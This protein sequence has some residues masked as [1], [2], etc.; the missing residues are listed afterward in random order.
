MELNGVAS[1]EITPPLTLDMSSGDGGSAGCPRR[2]NSLVIFTNAAS[3]RERRSS[4]VKFLKFADESSC[5]TFIAVFN[6]NILSLK[7]G[8]QQMVSGTSSSAGSKSAEPL[9][10]AH[11]FTSLY[12]SAM[13][14]RCVAI[15]VGASDATMNKKSPSDS[16]GDFQ[17]TS[18]TPVIL[19][20]CLIFPARWPKNFPLQ[21]LPG[22]NQHTEFSAVR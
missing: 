5:H 10:M 8:L 9:A 1:S 19:A 6:S 4:S 17:K 12:A 15:G 22:K 13:A 3:A 14:L 21:G 16:G 20:M 11:P 18:R 7:A 2:S